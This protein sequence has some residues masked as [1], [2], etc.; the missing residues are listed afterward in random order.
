V[1]EV[2]RDRDGGRRGDDENDKTVKMAE[3]VREAADDGNGW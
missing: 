2:D 1:V 3:T